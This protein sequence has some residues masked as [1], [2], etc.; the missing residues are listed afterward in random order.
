MGASGG[1]REGGGAGVKVGSDLCATYRST[2]VQDEAIEHAV[3]ATWASSERRLHVLACPRRGVRLLDQNR[4][5]GYSRS[6]RL[7]WLR[8][9]FVEDSQRSQPGAAVAPRPVPLAAT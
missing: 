6:C 5:T 3:Q 9:A 4:R 8:D 2:R 1:A 7:S